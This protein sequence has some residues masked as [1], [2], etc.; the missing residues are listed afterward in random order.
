MFT[1]EAY[2][3]VP[4][5]LPTS[6]SA[7]TCAWVVPFDTTGMGTP[8]MITAA[9]TYYPMQ[10]NDLVLIYN[11]TFPTS[12]TT[13]PFGTPWNLFTLSNSTTIGNV[14]PSDALTQWPHS[15]RRLRMGAFYTYTVTNTGNTPVFV[16]PFKVSARRNLDKATF[17]QNILNEY[18]NFLWNSG[19][20]SSVVGS[21]NEQS[22][23]A[24]FHNNQFD[25]FDASEFCST[26]KIRSKRS[27]TLAPG[28]SR[29]FS[30][31][32]KPR[33]W[34]M[35]LWFNDFI[36][37]AVST[38]HPWVR[39]KG[40]PEYV[41]K[42]T[43]GEGA[44]S[45]ITMANLYPA[46]AGQVTLPDYSDLD[47][48]PVGLLSCDYS[49]KYYCKPVPLVAPRSHYFMGATGN[50]TVSTTN[51]VTIVDSDVKNTAPAFN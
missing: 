29:T 9:N 43:T 50:G 3:K 33:T 48:Q 37:A 27:F 2:C 5:P 16:T 36:A 20:G 49:I 28:K 41:F 4:L 31:R 17:Q 15:Q 11:H 32:L 44:S 46:A 23:L 24:Y 26:W 45:A 21:I 1:R 47:N 39:F 30:I 6:G 8:T 40:V 42:Y 7:R 19:I 13:P 38:E 14:Y 12:S 18:I 35:R 22:M 51:T 34:N 25:L 10:A